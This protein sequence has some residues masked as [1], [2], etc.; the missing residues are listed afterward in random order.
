[1]EHALIAIRGVVIDTFCSF[2]FDGHKFIVFRKVSESRK[3]KNIPT[4]KL[5][6]MLN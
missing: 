4:D 6:E 3:Q 1:M 2:T 5:F